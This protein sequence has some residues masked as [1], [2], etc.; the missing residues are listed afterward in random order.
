MDL[1]VLVCLLT[2]VL[3]GAHEGFARAAW[4]F[5]GTLA[6]TT[7]GLLV[8]PS[9]LDDFDLSVWVSMAAVAL[10]GAFALG[11]RALALAAEKRVRTRVEMRVPSTL[12]RVAGGA[13]GLAIA[14]GV[15]WMV[16]LALAGSALP[17]V[18]AA[19]NQSRALE[20]LNDADLP[21]SH[22]I[23]D[24]FTR[25]GEEKDFPRY[26]D[27]FAAERIR[28]VD[29]APKSVATARG[30]VAASRSVWRLV[31]RDTAVT[32]SEGTGF[33]VAPGRLMTAAHVI[34][35]TQRITV[36]DGKN[37]HEATVIYCD[38]AHDVAVLDVPDLDGTVLT[39]A[40][41]GAD[42]DQLAAT[43]GYPGNGPLAI[44]AA[45]V[46]DVQ[47]WQTSNIWSEGRYE[48]DAVVIR[49]I[50]RGGNS[51]GPLVDQT[52]HV[53]GVVVASSRTDSA[54]GYVVTG[55]VVDQALAAARNPHATTDERCQR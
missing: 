43:I 2:G 5:T 48:Q 31:N 52:G 41:G 49:G 18:A 19:A 22:R 17:G 21:L 30:V 28:P 47:K 12:N 40:P 8:V 38:P 11:T 27:V 51:G 16:G 46:R 36:G 4:G 44:G 32:A 9:L 53:L 10:M 35:Q 13:F 33:L 55:D 37:P 50:V 20:L 14:V 1:A 34:D 6:G 24:R 45:R 39:F 25:L 54:T 29:P 23:L 3:L 26:V 7:A 42:A 15:S